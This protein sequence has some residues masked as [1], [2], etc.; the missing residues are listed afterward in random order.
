MELTKGTLKTKTIENLI[1]DFLQ[2][3]RIDRGAADHTIQAYRTDLHQFARWL[4][5]SVDL[6][7]M[8]PEGIQAF[9]SYLYDLK[10]RSTSLARK[11]STLKQFFKF[12]CREKGWV[13]NPM[14][15]IRSPHQSK[16][17]PEFLT[18]DQV[19]ALLKATHQGL[20]YPHGNQGDCLRARDRAMTYLLYATGL[21]ISELLSLTSHQVDLTLSYVKI[22]GKG[23]RERIAPFADVAGDF[24]RTYVDVYRP[25]LQPLTEHLFLNHRGFVLS[26]Q[27]FWKV[28]KSLAS[29]A[30]LPNSISPHILRHSFATHL[31]ESGMNLRSLQMLLGH[32][33]LSTTQIY[34]HISP[35]HLKVT[36]RK[37]HPRGED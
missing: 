3:Q 29:L 4:P 21:R 10:Q 17:L 23:D 1:E 8:D 35:E 9:L 33:D 18:V 13:A 19:N 22:K 5:E 24:V 34:T 12:C 2:F 30:D 16:R 14:E 6:E 26:R 25:H 20:P 32:S 31:L 11:T 15:K 27:A 36:H 28:L 7:R 37:F